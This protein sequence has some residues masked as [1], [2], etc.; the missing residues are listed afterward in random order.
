MNNKKT[1]Q[2][3]GAIAAATGDDADELRRWLS[4]SYA[5]R[6]MKVTAMTAIY[7][8]LGLKQRCREEIARYSALAHE[9]LATVDLPD[10]AKQTFG[11]V[12]DTLVDRTK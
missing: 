10:E 8:R 6:D 11:L 4:D 3:I 1:F 9:R 7:E 12:I 5:L 2:L